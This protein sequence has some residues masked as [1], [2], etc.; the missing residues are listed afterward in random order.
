MVRVRCL[1]IRHPHPRPLPKVEGA[2]AQYESRWGWGCY[3]ARHGRDWAIEL[4]GVRAVDWA[5]FVRFWRAGI[6]SS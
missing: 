2:S 1:P 4:R 3:G 6:L 5:G